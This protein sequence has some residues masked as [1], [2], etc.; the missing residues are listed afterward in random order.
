[1]NCEGREW[2]I[3][4]VRDEGGNYES[5]RT[6]AGT[7]WETRLGT[8]NREG[9][10]WELC[11]NHEGRGWE[12]WIMRDKVGNSVWIV[13]DE[14]GNYELW[15][16][17]VG[18]ARGTR[19]GTVN[20]EIRSWELFMN[21][22]GRGWELWIVR[23]EGGSYELWGARVGIMSCEGRGWE[24]WIVGDDGLSKTIF[25]QSGMHCMLGKVSSIVLGI[26]SSTFCLVGWIRICPNEKYMKLIHVVIYCHTSDMGVSKGHAT[27]DSRSIF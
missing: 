5:W 7:F 12:L 2:E 15:R 9:R 21:R 8:M 23:D 10:G 11:M 16:N 27:C 24:L 22:E 13:R 18:A 14:G 26:L 4:I 3:W 25:V 20:R 17:R 1:M 6:R 19:V